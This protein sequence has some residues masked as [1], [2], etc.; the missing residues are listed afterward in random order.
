[1]TLKEDILSL[2]EQGYSYNQI[3]AE[4]GCAKSTVA[5][6]CGPTQKNKQITRQRDRRTKFRK[7]MQA[8]K[9]N[10]VCMDCGVHYPYYVMDFDHR[11]DENKQFDISNINEIPSMEAL[12]EEINKC[13]I[14]CSNCHRH[15]TWTR[16]LTDGASAL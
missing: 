1:M 13:D 5:Y 8:A 4:L 2:R 6:Y 7:Y 14:V 12:I 3:I 9:E 16:L 10:A 11:P 15:R